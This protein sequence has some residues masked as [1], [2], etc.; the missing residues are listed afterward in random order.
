M[1]DFA[2]AIRTKEMSIPFP[3]KDSDQNVIAP[4]FPASG[5][6]VTNTFTFPVTAYWFPQGIDISN[7]L[8]NGVSIG[9]TVVKAVVPAGQTIK[10][11]YTKPL[12]ALP[13]MW[14]WVS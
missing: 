6:A 13:P 2:T 11:V 9:R 12:D 4:N 5:V 10:F 14:S 3:Q 8:V 7:I 1:Q